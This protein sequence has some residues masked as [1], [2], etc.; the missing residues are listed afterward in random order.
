MKKDKK[1]EYKYLLGDS[2]KKLKEFE[3]GK[4]KL[5]ITSPPLRP[6]A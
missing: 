6:G 4:F 2:L 1:T 3:N 5:I